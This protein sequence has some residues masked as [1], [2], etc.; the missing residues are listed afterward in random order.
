MWSCVSTCPQLP[1]CPNTH[2]IRRYFARK[3]GRQLQL[4]STAFGYDDEVFQTRKTSAAGIARKPRASPIY[5]TY[6]GTCLHQ[7]R[8][9]PTQVVFSHLQQVSDATP[10]LNLS[11]LF[12]ACTPAKGAKPLSRVPG[13]KVYHAI[14]PYMHKNHEQ[15]T[16]PLNRVQAFS[17][18][19]KHLCVPIRLICLVT[20][21]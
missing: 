10:V 9:Q 20:P 16:L 12:E 7:S 8:P 18:S 13:A 21:I 11:N 14:C 1:R 3:V 15:Y 19:S 6:V 2:Q 5:S 4:T 17:Y